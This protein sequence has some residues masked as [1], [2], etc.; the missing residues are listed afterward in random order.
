MET[1]LFKLM[2]SKKAESMTLGDLLVFGTQTRGM[3]KTR[4]KR[5]DGKYGFGSVQRHPGG[6]RTN[7]ATTL[8]S[9]RDKAAPGKIL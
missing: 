9:P 5:N 3:R 4:V 8:F 6:S 1:G 2:L 7:F